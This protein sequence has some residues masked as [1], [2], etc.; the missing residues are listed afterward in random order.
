MRRALVVGIDNYSA[1]P[2]SGC[3][4]DAKRLGNILSSHYDKSPN[5]SCKFVLSPMERITRSS[6]RKDIE[7]LFRDEADVALLYFSGHG[8]VNNLGGYLVTPD[9]VSYDEGVSMMDVLT[10]ADR[11]KAQEVIIILDCCH[12]G[13]FGQVPVVNND[14]A[15]LREGVSVLTASRQS[16]KAVEIGGEGLFTSLICDALEGGAADLIGDVTVAS[17]YAH[18]DQALGPWDQRPL[19]K[20]HVSKLIKVRRA[21]SIIEPAI[22]R[23][24]PEIFKS[25]NEEVKLDPTY[26]HTFKTSEEEHKMIFDCL[27]QYNRAGLVVPVGAKH[28]YDAAMNS[29]SCKL[30]A[31]GKFYWR[32]ASSNQI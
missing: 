20:S 2:L 11:S 6:L 3:V 18:V 4:N 9:A 19:F 32:V 12:S 17:I 31:R 30:T 5:F 29:K 13:A 26:E 27:Q 16:Q 23:R 8:T 25:P 22:I 7:L 28:M 1:S 15:I 21:N 24:L 10:F 14:S